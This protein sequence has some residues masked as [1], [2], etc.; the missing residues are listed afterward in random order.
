MEDRGQNAEKSVAVIQRKKK[1]KEKLRLKTASAAVQ[2]TFRESGESPILP[3]RVE[4]E[5]LAYEVVV[6]YLFE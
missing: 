6:L 5:E 2:T 1:G 3:R 4:N